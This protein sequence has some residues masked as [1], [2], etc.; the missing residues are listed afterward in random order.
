[1]CSGWERRAEM[2]AGPSSPGFHTELQIWLRRFANAENGDGCS[3]DA[4]ANHELAI[5]P[6]TTRREPDSAYN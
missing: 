3:Q 4:R 5:K 2:R 1:M 6:E